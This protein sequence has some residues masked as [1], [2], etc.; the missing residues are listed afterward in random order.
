MPARNPL[1]PGEVFGRL[2]VIGEG[3]HRTTPQG[4]TIYR[5]RA[6]CACGTEIE[7]NENSL[8]QRHTSSCGCLHRELMTSHGMSR[9][10]TYRIWEGMKQRGQARGTGGPHYAARGTSVC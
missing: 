1:K 9:S 4:A 3:T 10:R 5:A 7:A 6:L 2:V 8:R